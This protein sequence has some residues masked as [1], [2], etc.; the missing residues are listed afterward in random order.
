MRWIL[1]M[2][3]LVASWAGA[4]EGSTW[5][6]Y[7]FKG[8][9]HFKYTLVQVDEKGNKTEGHY[10]LDINRDGDKYTLKVEGKFGDNEGSTTVK[11]KD[12]NEL[13]GT[14]MMQMV[15]NPWL[16][17]FYATLFAYQLPLVALG[18]GSLEPGSK[19]VQKQGDKVYEYS[20]ET[21]SFKGKEGRRFVA[22]EDGK[23]LFEV[24]TIPDIAMPVYVQSN[25]E[26]GESYEA[27]LVEYKE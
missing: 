10:I 25:G 5:E 22:K 27:K 13:R 9:E 7:Q 8:T 18:T 16:G 20:V 4:E 12:Q 26:E 23:T 1:P 6:P 19:T 15:F 17:P 11:V 14:L 3:L 21:C 24:C 2:A